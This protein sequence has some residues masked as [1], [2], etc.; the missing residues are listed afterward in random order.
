MQKLT[1]R[2]VHEN[3]TR[4][5][6]LDMH[7]EHKSGSLPPVEWKIK[8]YKTSTQVH[9]HARTRTHTHTH[10]H[11][12]EVDFLLQFSLADCAGFFKCQM[13]KES[14]I[15]LSVL[16]HAFTKLKQYEQLQENCNY[17]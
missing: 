11:H 5:F 8:G 17:S 14:I 4:L 12:T 9:T 7:A 13:S 2:V 15:V 16:F 6:H 10:T 1:E 3:I